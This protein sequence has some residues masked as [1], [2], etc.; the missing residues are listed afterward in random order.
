MNSANFNFFTLYVT[1]ADREAAVNRLV[2]ALAGGCFCPFELNILD[3]DDRPHIL[4]RE[5]I[6]ATPALVREWPAPR[7]L[8]QGDLAP[9]DSVRQF[10]HPGC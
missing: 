7:A 5:H 8:F 6:S 1:A 3:V 9:L 10:L 4:E 2:E